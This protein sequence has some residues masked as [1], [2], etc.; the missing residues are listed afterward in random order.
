MLLLEGST[1]PTKEKKQ[2]ME[3]QT[4]LARLLVKPKPKKIGMRTT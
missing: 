3:A 1:S 2:V 4:F